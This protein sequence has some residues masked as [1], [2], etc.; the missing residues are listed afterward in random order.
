L[1]RGRISDIEAQLAPDLGLRIH[2]SHW[3]AARAVAALHRGASWS[4]RLL[5]G[6]ELPVARARREAARAW[7]AALGKPIH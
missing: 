3:V 6:S 4:V 1:L 5:D 7:V 2:R